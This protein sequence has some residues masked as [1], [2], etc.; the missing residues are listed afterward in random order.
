ML[1]MTVMYVSVNVVVRREDDE[2]TC[3]VPALLLKNQCQDHNYI[4]RR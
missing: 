3:N 2:F 1:S 4:L